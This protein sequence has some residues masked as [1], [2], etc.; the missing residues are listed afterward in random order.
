MPRVLISGFGVQSPFTL[1]NR[2]LA[3]AGLISSASSNVRGSSK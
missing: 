1:S 3:M 2:S